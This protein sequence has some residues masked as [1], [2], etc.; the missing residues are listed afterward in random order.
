MEHNIK[1]STL[2]LKFPPRPV[3]RHIKYLPEDLGM[4]RGFGDIWIR[5]SPAGVE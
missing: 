1:S 4:K 2:G 5:G 3:V